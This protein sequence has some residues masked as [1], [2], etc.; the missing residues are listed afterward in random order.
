MNMKWSEQ[1]YGARLYLRL[2]LSKLK[3]MGS[4]I[5]LYLF[6][7]STQKII[8]RGFHMCTTQGT[9]LKYKWITNES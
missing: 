8:H 4:Y 9:F 5:Y 2:L 1:C 6:G 3:T 7:D